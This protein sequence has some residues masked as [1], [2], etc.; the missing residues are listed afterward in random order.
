MR[1]LRAFVAAVVAALALGAIA[2]AQAQAT[3]GQTVLQ[4]MFT[5]KTLDPGILAPS[6]AA[7][8]PISALQAIVDGL[9]A[10]LGDLKSIK[11]TDAD[12][13]LTFSKGTL[14]ATIALDAQNKITTLHFTD[15]A[16]PA[17][18]AALQRVLSATHVQA[19]WFAPSFLAAVPAPQVDSNLAQIAASEGKF[20][21]VDLT[22]GRYYA[23]YEKASNPVQIG[24]DGQGRI[25]T[26]FLGPAVAPA[27]SF[28]DAVKRSREAPA[29]AI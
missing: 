10:Q 15:E 9:R 24:L 8:L 7:A 12:Y 6:A 29:I 14:R 3:P 23:V 20:V 11:A 18:T 13:R 4:T 27:T 1:T 25:A 19:D 2:Q 21:K 17:S 22:D 26:L 28:D 16:S 5:A